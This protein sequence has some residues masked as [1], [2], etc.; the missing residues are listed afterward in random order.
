MTRLV[1]RCSGIYERWVFALVELPN[2]LTAA[3]LTKDI[4]PVQSA[5]LFGFADRL[6]PYVGIADALEL[7]VVVLRQHDGSSVAIAS[8]DS[9]YPGKVQASLADA[10]GLPLNQVLVAASHTHF[11]PALDDH[12]GKLGCA[13][14]SYLALVSSRVQETSVELPMPTPVTIAASQ[15]TTHGLSVCRRKGT[16][17]SMVWRGGAF[18]TIQAP[19]PFQPIDTSVHVLCI[20][21]D[22]CVVAVIWSFACHPVCCP[23]RHSVSSDFVGRV[24]SRLRARL[25]PVP[26]LFLQGFSGDV[27]PNFSTRWP[28]KQPAQFVKW[29]VAG[30]VRFKAPSLAEYDAWCDELATTVEDA[31]VKAENIDSPIVTIDAVSRDWAGSTRPITGTLIRL[32]SVGILGVSPYRAEVNSRF[33]GFLMTA[34][35]CNEMI[36]YWPTDEM[37]ADGGYEGV[38]S[39]EFF[40][41]INWDVAG[42]PAAAFALLLDDLGMDG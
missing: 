8:V 1:K 27:R 36:G 6:S 16:P 21:N 33:H 10:L 40:P 4:S 42:G 17:L 9:L 25:G 28:S 32:G 38:G 31:A 15:V 24:R 39:T 20:R 7:N 30:C 34:G 35:C 23:D 37:I 41:T 11:A 22:S 19:N 3:A 13:D 18:G 2:V 5:S 12:L 14:P 26:V 29:C